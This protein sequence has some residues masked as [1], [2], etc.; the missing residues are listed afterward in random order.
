MCFIIHEKYPEEKIAKKDIVCYKILER[1]STVDF[2]SPYQKKHYKLNI[3]YRSRLE[4]SSYRITID[5]GIHSYSCK[6][7]ATYWINK[8]RNGVLAKGIIPKGSRYYYNP[9]MHEYVSNR[10]ILQKIIK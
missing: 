7:K 4:L 2:L 8:V 3:L 5:I 10:I 9:T 1:N 6:K